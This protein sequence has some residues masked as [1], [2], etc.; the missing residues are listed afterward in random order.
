MILMI[1]MMMTVDNEDERASKDGH[2][3]SLMFFQSVKEDLSSGESQNT[4][5]DG[6]SIGGH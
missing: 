1:L 3:S 2:P 6:W 4:S 5:N